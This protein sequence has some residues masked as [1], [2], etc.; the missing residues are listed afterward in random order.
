MLY[1]QNEIIYSWGRFILSIVQVIVARSRHQHVGSCSRSASV[2]QADCIYYNENS[3]QVGLYSHFYTTRLSYVCAAVRRPPGSYSFISYSV[4]LQ[5]VYLVLRH[6]LEYFQNYYLYFLF[7]YRMSAFQI[8]N[9][10]ICWALSLLFTSQHTKIS[11]SQTVQL[12]R[13]W[14]IQLTMTHFPLKTF[15]FPRT[16]TDQ[17]SFLKS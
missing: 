11:I 7:K 15:A 4:L 3:S 5:R 14:E 12:F 8:F 17:K 10:K 2:I 16:P 9:L 13:N 6:L 1:N